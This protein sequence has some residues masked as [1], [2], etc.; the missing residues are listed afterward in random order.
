MKKKGAGRTE[1]VDMIATQLMDCVEQITDTQNLS[2]G[3]K[4][5]ACQKIRDCIDWMRRGKVEYRVEYDKQ[6]KANRKGN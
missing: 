2:E 6:F 3:A 1:T 5:M 4:V